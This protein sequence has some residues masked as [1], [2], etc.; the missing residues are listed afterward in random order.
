MIR[1]LYFSTA[2]PSVSRSDVRTLVA[3]S[4]TSN[5]KHGIT[6]ALGFN[7]RNF[8]QV[9]EGDEAEVRKLLSVI[10]QDKRHSGFKILD[11]KQIETRYF[12]DWSMHLVESLDFSILMD[13]MQA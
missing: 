10:A 4:S 9:L 6:G 5:E 8:C 13:A 12:P 7:G 11:E 3:Q 2:L 1:I